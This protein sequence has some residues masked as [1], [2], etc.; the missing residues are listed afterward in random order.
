MS[1]IKKMV[2][3]EDLK[4]HLKTLMPKTSKHG[5]VA[6]EDVRIANALLDIFL[7]AEKKS[8]EN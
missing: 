7:W 3:L 6:N 8:Q 4:E 5:K 1:E 2:P